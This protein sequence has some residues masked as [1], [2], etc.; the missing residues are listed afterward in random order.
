MARAKAYPKNPYNWECQV[1]RGGDLNCQLCLTSHHLN[2]GSL[3]LQG[4]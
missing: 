4:Y 1:N 3:T 2:G